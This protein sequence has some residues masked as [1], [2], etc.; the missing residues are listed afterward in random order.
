MESEGNYEVFG[1]ADAEA[2]ARLRIAAMAFDKYPKTRRDA[3]PTRVDLRCRA[4]GYGV[5]VVGP[6]PA[7]PIC[8]A[9][10]WVPVTRR[11]DTRDVI[12]R[13]W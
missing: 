5:V 8:H 1:R 9:T 2:W 10:D 4:C 12:E 3:E 13:T 7:C 11:R 6:P